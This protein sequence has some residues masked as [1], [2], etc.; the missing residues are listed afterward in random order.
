VETNEDTGDE[1]GYWYDN[2]AAT[3]AILH[4]LRRFRRADQE[5][6]RRMS[7]DM[8]MNVS[9]MQALQ[10]VIAAE[11]QGEPATPRDLSALLGISSASTTKLL[12]RL[13]ASGHLERHPHPTDRRALVLRSTPF[14]HSEIRARMQRMHSGMEQAAAAVPPESRAAVVALLDAMASAM[15]GSDEDEG[16]DGTRPQSPRG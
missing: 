5:M 11:A 12:D 13:S 3:T 8:D 9:D 2:T 14:A 16:T 10:H 15:A 7:A 4:A 1:H 6:R